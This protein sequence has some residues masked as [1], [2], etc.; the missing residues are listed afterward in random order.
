METGF[1]HSIQFW[2][3]ERVTK[4]SIGDRDNR[5]K[6]RSRNNVWQDFPDRPLEDRQTSSPG[7]IQETL[8]QTLDQ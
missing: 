1:I 2:I 3:M 5:D 6:G 8:N 7:T 4:H